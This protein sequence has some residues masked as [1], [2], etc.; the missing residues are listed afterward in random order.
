MN[1][2]ALTMTTVSM[3]NLKRRPFRTGCLVLLV[4]M[5]AYVLFGGSML[6]ASLGNGMDSMAKRLGA[7]ALV[8]PAGYEQNVEGALLR[9]EPSTFYFNAAI[10]DRV[11]GVEGVDEVSAQLFIAS[12]S[13]DCCSLPVQL[14]GFDPDTDFVIRPWLATQIRGNLADGEVMA[15]SSLNVDVGDV[16]TFFDREY[17]VAACL[18]RT[19]MGF[20]TSVF[21]NM[22]SARQ[23]VSD[24]EKAGGRLAPPEGNSVS[25]LVLNVQRGYDVRE[26]AD[27]ILK[28]YGEEGVD[29]VVTKNMLSSVS[30]GLG[31]LLLFILILAAILWVLAIGVLVTV[32]SIALNERKREFGIL[33]ALGA[34]RRKLVQIILCESALIS[35]AGSAIGIVFACLTLFPFRTYIG[36][37]LERPYLQ[38][39]VEEVLALLAASLLISFATG[40]LASIYAAV[41]IGKSETYTMMREDE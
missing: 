24:Y 19:G 40:P 36:I 28:A 4:A 11:A 10:A 39:P 21:M 14:I 13:A 30:G 29:A 26:V 34:T 2:R 12:F 41:K 6:A 1:L 35:L 38:P 5:F 3:Q 32:F 25:S 7:D 15:G 22:T 18:D 37:S 33:R 9:G 16:L 31:A 8:V 20:D 23:A 17:R 27:N